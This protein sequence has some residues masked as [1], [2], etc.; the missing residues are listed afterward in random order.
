MSLQNQPSE[1][2]VQL[3]TLLR[4]QWHAVGKLS[5]QDALE[6]HAIEQEI[7]KRNS[8]IHQDTVCGAYVSMF[9]RQAA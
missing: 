6:L 9:R 8:Y 4:D 5:S 1:H 7:A 2:L 3:A